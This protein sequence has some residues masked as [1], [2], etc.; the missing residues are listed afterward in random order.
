MPSRKDIKDKTRVY[1]WSAKVDFTLGHGGGF[2][3]LNYFR[4]SND[5]VDRN[6]ALAS[7]LWDDDYILILESRAIH[8]MQE[9]AGVFGYRLTIEADDTASGAENLGMRLA[10]ALLTVAVD[11]R[12]GLALSWPESPLPCRVIDRTASSG[13]QGQGF[14]T[15]T[16]F[17]YLRDFIPKLQAGFAAHENVPYRLLLSMELFTTSK[18]ESNSRSK[19][20]MLVSALESLA[21]Q[22]DME[23]DVGGLVLKLLEVVGEADFDDPS[24][25]ASIAGQVKN[26]T[27]ESARRAMKR[28]VKGQG[29]TDDDAAFLEE[30]YAAR[31]KIVH[32]GKRVPELETMIHRLEEILGRL[33]LTY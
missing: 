3:E 12:W 20:I 19:L 22:R 28:L 11:L 25:K 27:R 16:S 29:L 31:S 30:A 32:E 15:I 10:F 7:L 17:A 2:H 26:L 4:E 5:P 6:K 21:E 14:A 23:K 13:I 9:A 33:Y 1:S 24:L 8:P 18:L